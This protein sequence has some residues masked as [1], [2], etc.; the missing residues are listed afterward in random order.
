L[1]LTVIRTSRTLLGVAAIA[2]VGAAL[3]IAVPAI[4]APQHAA[5][6]VTAG[7]YYLAL[8]DSAPFGYRELT[9]APTPDR[10]NAASFRGYPE[11]VGQELGL[12][13]MNASCPGETSGSFIDVTAQSNGCEANSDGVPQAGYRTN[14]PLHVN[15]EDSQ[16]AYGE[17][18]LRHH[19]KSTK[20]VTLMIG[21]NDGFICQKETVD[22][23][24]SP[25]EI[26]PIV[27]Q[28]AANVTKIVKAL[29][30][31]GYAGQILTVDYYSP[32]YND[33]ATTL[34][35]VAI[36]NG[37]DSGA[38]ADSNTYKVRV[39]TPFGAFK[40]ASAET[41]GD[42][43][44]AGLLTI[45]TGDMTPCGVHPSVAGQFVIAS[46]VVEKIRT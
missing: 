38:R 12:K 46:K 26:G 9:N 15:Y 30:K 34:G 10:T 20:L 6:P 36:N 35:A 44:A 41:S 5:P 43:C 2:V 39:A 17:S 3:A 32:D 14:Y 19:L 13:V 33:A 21:A 24:T 27:Q 37:L 11:L 8:G 40:V 28:I 22:Q 7:S 16:L 18:F 31:T 1:T 45:L 4:A 25:A 42:P 29:R 23:C